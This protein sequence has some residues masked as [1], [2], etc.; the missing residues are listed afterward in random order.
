MN[1]IKTGK[2]AVAVALTCAVTVPAVMAG[3]AKQPTLSDADFE[4]AKTMYFQ[5]CAG[6]HGVLRKGATGKNL[7]P[8]ST[9]K[10]GQSRLE[11]ILTYGTEGGM[12][13]FNDI[14]T[15]MKLN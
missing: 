1:I 11:K 14:F 15:K 10:L 13:N 5:R 8:K 2:L 12:N 6:C 7:E 3:A 4:K 9:A